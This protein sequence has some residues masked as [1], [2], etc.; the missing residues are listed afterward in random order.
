M[1]E[2]DPDDRLKQKTHLSVEGAQTL[3]GL[4]RTT[5]L[6]VWTL[7]IY[8]WISIPDGIEGQDE[9]LCQRCLTEYRSQEADQ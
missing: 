6:D 1:N 8:S 3:C 7:E 4:T 2:N 5:K 9:T